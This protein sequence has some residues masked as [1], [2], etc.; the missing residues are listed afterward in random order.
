VEVACSE[1]ESKFNDS[2]M[3]SVLDKV[4]STKKRKFVKSLK[5]SRK[6]EDAGRLPS[7]MRWNEVQLDRLYLRGGDVGFALFACGT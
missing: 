1:D 4:C 2:A 5:W 7:G 6:S 3:L